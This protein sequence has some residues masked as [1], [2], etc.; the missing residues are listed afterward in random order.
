[1]CVC[2]CVSKCERARER[3]K[4]EKERGIKVIVVRIY[5]YVIK[6]GIHVFSPSC[7]KKLPG[8]LGFLALLGT[9]GLRGRKYIIQNLQSVVCENLWHIVYHSCHHHYKQITC[10][11]PLT[12]HICN[13]PV[14]PSYDGTNQYIY[15]HIYFFFFL[16][17]VYIGSKLLFEQVL[18]KSMEHYYF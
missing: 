12:V 14:E 1:M 18:L 5:F 6:T 17:S 3:E 7:E 11:D 15:I 13:C 16:K 9:T 8:R 2:V 4:R 10:V